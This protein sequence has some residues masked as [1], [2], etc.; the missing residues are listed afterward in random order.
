M[1]LMRV[2]NMN[3]LLRHMQ[4]LCD[5]NESARTEIHVDHFQQLFNIH[6]KIITLLGQNANPSQY[7]RCAGV[8][9]ETQC[10]CHSNV[11]VL[12]YSPDRAHLC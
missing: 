7:Q 12:F 9:V 8:Q 1:A 3:L 10:V 4:E 11:L 5:T 6:F 2:D